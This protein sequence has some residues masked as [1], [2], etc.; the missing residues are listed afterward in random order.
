M[1]AFLKHIRERILA[2][3]IFLV[4]L[5]AIV[6]ILQ[7]LWSKLSGS[8]HYLA[9]LLGLKLVLGSSAA[10]I[11]TTIL[12]VIL[13]YFF[14]WLVKF[15]ALNRT[16]DWIENKVLQYIPGYLVYKAQISDKLGPKTDNRIPVWVVTDM[17]KRPALLITEQGEDAIVYFPNSPDSNNGTVSLV[18]R[19]LLT[20]LDISATSFTKSLQKFGK[21]LLAK[22]E[23]MKLVEKANN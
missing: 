1:K 18:S 10:P 15:S 19:N 7:K 4:P 12:L 16:R 8:G 22:N 3:L 13:F 6:L 14:G 21:D 5:F 17:G 20:K 23:N 9:S 11:V 2:G